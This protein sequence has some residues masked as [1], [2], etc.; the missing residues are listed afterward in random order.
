MKRKIN[1]TRVPIETKESMRWLDNLRRSVDLVGEPNRCIH[2]GDRES[3]IFELCCLACELGA[4]FLVR[5][6]VDR[7]A[8]DS[9]C[10][11]AKEMV[12]AKTLGQHTIALHGS[13]GKCREVA[14]DLNVKHMTV[15]PP[16]GKFKRYRSLVLTVLHVTERPKSTTRKKIKELI[17][18]KLLT[19]LEVTDNAD[20]IE[21]LDWYA[22]RWNIETFHKVLKSGCKAEEARLRTVERLANLIAVFC[23][24]SW[25]ILWL[26]M[27]QRTAPKPRSRLRR[28]PCSISS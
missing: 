13:D 23:I 14:L 25:R 28:L 18:W 16:I 3:D 19:D 7:L 22:M 12:D 6:C 1:P 11:I 17:E 20:A 21:K 15:L 26:A 2:D 10:T 27:V 4:H 9:K 24:L 5:T 8:R